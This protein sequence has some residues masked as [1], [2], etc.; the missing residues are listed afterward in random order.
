MPILPL[1]PLQ[2]DIEAFL[3][4]APMDLTKEGLINLAESLYFNLKKN[5]IKISVINPGFIES[6]STNLNSFKMPFLR[7]TE[8]AANKIYKGL[9]GTYKFEI[10]FPWFFL[11]LLKILKILSYKLYFYLIKKI[12]KL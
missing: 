2:W 5:K 8:F 9:T 6:E 11:L 4:Q 3:L 7:S 1:Y 10:Y 12:T